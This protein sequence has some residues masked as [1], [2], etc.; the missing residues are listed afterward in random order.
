MNPPELRPTT[1]EDLLALLRKMSQMDPAPATHTLHTAFQSPLNAM[2]PIPPDFEERSLTPIPLTLSSSTTPFSAANENNFSRSRGGGNPQSIHIFEESHPV[3]PVSSILERPR[4][5]SQ[6]SQNY[7]DGSPRQILSQES[8]FQLESQ[9]QTSPNSPSIYSPIVTPEPPEPPE[10]ENMNIELE[11]KGTINTDGSEYCFPSPRNPTP[12]NTNAYYETDSAYQNQLG[13]LAAPVEIDVKKAVPGAGAEA[14]HV[15]DQADY[16]PFSLPPRSPFRPERYIDTAELSYLSNEPTRLAN[17]PD[18]SRLDPDLSKVVVDKDDSVFRTKKSVELKVDQTFLRRNTTND[19]LLLY[20]SR[21]YLEDIPNV[22]QLVDI[23]FVFSAHQL[24]RGTEFA[25]FAGPLRAKHMVDTYLIPHESMQAYENQ[26]VVLGISGTLD[27]VRSGIHSFLRNTVPHPQKFTLWR[28]N[29]LV[30]RVIIQ[31]LLGSRED[32]FNDYAPNASLESSVPILRR[33]LG[34]IYGPIRGA[35]KEHLLTIES[36]SFSIIMNAIG[37]VGRMLVEHNVPQDSYQGYYRGGKKSVIP[38]DM[39]L[40]WDSGHSTTAMDSRVPVG[41]VLRPEIKSRLKEMHRKRYHLQFIMDVEHA[42]ILAGEGGVLIRHH[43]GTLKVEICISDEILTLENRGDRFRVCDIGGDG[44]K[45]IRTASGEIMHWMGNIFLS[46]YS[47]SIYIPHRVAIKANE[48]YDPSF[49]HE[50]VSLPQAERSTRL[51]RTRLEPDEE[52][53]VLRIWS[54][55][56]DG[57]QSGVATVLDAIY[58]RGNRNTGSVGSS[59][60]A[61]QSMGSG[62]E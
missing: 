6:V 40:S 4:D 22:N 61:Q 52:E 1:H 50:I 33:A 34:R 5:Y 35:E 51:N 17:T 60:Q 59:N 10:L 21:A 15:R 41:Y 32:D 9:V 57:F 20:H 7:N 24:P 8:H 23:R 26:D 49:Q 36:C 30:P 58:D 54:Q 13:P 11:E 28:F 19:P 18:H 62:G 12:K 53:S 45:S 2:P 55:K 56:G 27:R 46:E 47:I 37:Y 48:W 39:K 38:M 42:K 43:C 16:T 44:L 3:H 25:H 14:G 29:L 31:S